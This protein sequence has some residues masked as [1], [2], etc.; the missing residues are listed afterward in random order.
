MIVLH[1]ASFSTYVGG[2]EAVHPVRCIERS[3]VSARLAYSRIFGGIW[4][5]F[6]FI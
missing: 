3:L 4:A 1:L 6:K 2:E 5:H